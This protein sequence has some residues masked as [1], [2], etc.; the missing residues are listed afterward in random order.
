MA[1]LNAL[2][3]ATFMHRVIGA[4]RLDARTFEEI[5]AD[6]GATAQS[7]VVVL[8]A[9]AATGVG[10]RGLQPGVIA[11]IAA[12]TALAL[13][14]WT[15]R[16]IVTFEI[17]AHVIPE[18][19]TRADVSELLRTLGF[20]SAPGM[21][22]VFAIVPALAAPVFVVTSVWMLAAM[23]VAVRQ[24][25]DYRSTRRAIVVCVVGWVL[26]VGFIYLFGIVLGMRV[27]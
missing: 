4:A 24:A 13:V 21:L 23:I 15:V 25:L 11:A 22:R 2:Q 26:V 20:A 12:F 18:P 17:G 14:A 6:R 16:S 5:E 3:P 9:G 8:L 19:G 27:Q 7:A 10:A 1:F